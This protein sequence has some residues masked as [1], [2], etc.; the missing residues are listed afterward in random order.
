[1]HFLSC[2]VSRGEKFVGSEE[3]AAGDRGSDRRCGICVLF[4][5]AECGWVTGSRGW[6]GGIHT[7]QVLQLDLGDV[8]QCLHSVD[9]AQR[10]VCFEGHG[11]IARDLLRPVR[12]QQTRM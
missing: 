4:L 1:M 11:T 12:T 7:W 9:V 10:S 8:A 3:N 6:V 5:T 2:G